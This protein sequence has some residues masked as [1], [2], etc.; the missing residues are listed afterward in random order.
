[1]ALEFEWDEEKANTNLRKHGIAFE[2]ATT[3][4]SDP[5]L[6]TIDDPLH[7]FDEE[8]F[9]NIGYST[10]LR[11]LVVVHTERKNLI[12]IISARK[13]TKREREIYE[14]GV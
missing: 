7:S 13:A 8:P 9:V 11:V 3:I 1:M 2:E 10:K 14:Q 5:F 12:R 4:F 6:I